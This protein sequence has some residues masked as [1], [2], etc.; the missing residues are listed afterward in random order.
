MMFQIQIFQ[1]FM[2][3]AMLSIVFV[4]SEWI[5]EMEGKL[6]SIFINLFSFSFTI[7]PLLIVDSIDF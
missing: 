3:L 4:R 1:V 2:I 7:F 5:K 6:T